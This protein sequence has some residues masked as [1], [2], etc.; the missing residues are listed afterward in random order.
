MRLS[1]FNLYV[2]NYPEQGQTLVHNTF[3]GS[4][5]V[6]E[7]G[8]LELLR[9]ADRGEPL[10]CEEQAIAADPELS[11]PDVGVLVTSRKQEESDFRAWFER[12][13][14]RREL[15]VIVGVNLACNFECPYCCQA[16]VMSGK[17]MSEEHCDATGDWLVAHALDHELELIRLTFVGGEPLLHPQRLERIARR[18]RDQAGPHG[19]AVELNLL[20]NGYFLD[21]AMVQRLLPLGLVFAKVTLD[22]DETTHHL[23]RVHKKGEDTFARIFDNVIAASRHIRVT[24]NGNYG[25]ETVHGFAPLVEKLA[26]AG[27]ASG[28]NLSFSPALAGLASSGAGSCTWSGTDTSLQMAL[29]DHILRHGF[30]AAPANVIGPC[31]FHDRHSFAIDPAG[32]VYKCPGFLGNPEWA[33]GHVTSGLT[34]RYRDLVELNPQRECTGCAHRPNCGG[35]CV[36]AQWLKLG[37]AEGVNCERSYFDSVQTGSLV[38]NYLLATSS[39]RSEAL[40]S[41]PDATSSLEAARASR[42]QPQRGRRASSLRVIAA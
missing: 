7:E 1:G 9:R 23:T 8:T 41:F 24:V 39:D 14:S 21:A 33:I 6:L 19:I 4:Y 10:T 11:D 30:D 2:E 34:G 12:R 25:P 28:S 3:A 42:P 18:V 16:E 13:R 31:E 40:A 22:G 15:D 35:G 17:V 38:R 36:A 26:A 29:H 32:I 20:T 37:R 27:L 5:V